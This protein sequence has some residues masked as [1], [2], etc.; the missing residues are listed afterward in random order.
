LGSSKVATPTRQ[1]QK[2]EEKLMFYF[3]GDLFTKYKK[4]R[5]ELFVNV[6]GVLSS[7]YRETPKKRLKKVKKKSIGLVFSKHTGGGSVD[8]FAG[9]PPSSTMCDSPCPSEHDCDFGS[10]SPQSYIR[11]YMPGVLEA[12]PRD[13]IEICYIR[14]ESEV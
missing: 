4:F 9:A 12:V 6:Y 10:G 2:N 3:W 14:H 5:Q 8:F 11:T 7:P 13:G 1:Q